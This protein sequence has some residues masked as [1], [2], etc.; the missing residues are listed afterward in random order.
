VDREWRVPHF[1]KML[2]DN[3][4]LLPLYAESRV[5]WPEDAHLA[6]VP[7]GIV[8]W[9]EEELADGRGTW[10]AALDADSEGEEG[11][12]YV[13]TPQ[14]LEDVLGR[15]AGQ[16]LAADLGVTPE[17]NFEH[18]RSV[19]YRPHARLRAAEGYAERRARLLEVRRRRVPPARDDK[20]LTSWNALAVSGLARAA[21]AL[22]VVGD[23]AVA[24]RLGERAQRA[25]RRLQACHLHAEG[26]PA[27][28]CIAQQPHGA[29]FLDDLAY[30]ARAALDVHEWDLDPA[31]LDLAGR[32]AAAAVQ[33]HG[34]PGGDRFYFV[35]D[36]GERLLERSEAPH[37]GAVPSGLGVLLE[38]LAR[39]EPTG[40]APEG[41]ARILESVFTRRRAAATE[42]FLF[43]SVVMA[44]RW[45][46]ADAIHVGLAGPDRTATG[47]R[48]LAK[49]VDRVRLG[50]AG[51]ITAPVGLSWRDGP[52]LSV[53][54]CRAG[55]CAQLAPQ[56]EALAVWLLAHAG[57]C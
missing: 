18:G 8:A 14:E 32:L 2:Y 46:R 37:D 38:V 9:L 23:D 4:Q 36:D 44:A 51:P 7:V 57:D 27:R 33:R 50:A 52:T 47:A 48:A 29:G 56:E 19:L 39:L 6:E 24:E 43:A 55:A 12:Y 17:G 13:W 41:T 49:A 26:V 3:A 1:E 34:T 5:L 30:L 31:W 22:R 53:Q 40:V 28:Q 20:V 42:P 54:V 11:R 10:A 15:D 16:M 21:R 35:P 45:A 25:L